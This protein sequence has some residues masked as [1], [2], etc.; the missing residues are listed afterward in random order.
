MVGNWHVPWKRITL[1]PSSSW[2]IYPA[3]S[4]FTSTAQPGSVR[5]S[6]STQGKARFCIYINLEKVIEKKNSNRVFSPT[7]DV[8]YPIKPRPSTPPRPGDSCLRIAAPWPA[9]RFTEA[10]NFRLSQDSHLNQYWWNKKVT[11]REWS[12]H[13]WREGYHTSRY[14][15]CL[16]DLTGLIYL[17]PLE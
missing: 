7:L 4:G 12:L 14:D 3:T 13:N 1:I 6:P 5:G 11:R 16:R 9:R 17:S 10:A 15:K 8:C 2:K